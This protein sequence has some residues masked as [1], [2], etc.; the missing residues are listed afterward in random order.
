MTRDG[1][2]AEADPTLARCLGALREAGVDV[3][4]ATDDFSELPERLARRMF[5]NPEL[6]PLAVLL[7][8]RGAG[9]PVGLFARGGYAVGTVELMMRLAALA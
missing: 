9:E 1:A 5:A 4:L 8:C 2:A 3:A 6:L 7:D